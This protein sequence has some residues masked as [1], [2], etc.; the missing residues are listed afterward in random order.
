MST[1]NCVFSHAPSSSSLCL[2]SDSQVYSLRILLL[3]DAALCIC[4][5]EDRTTA[6]INYSMRTPMPQSPLGSLPVCHQH[7]F[8]P[9]S[10]TYVLVLTPVMIVLSQL[11]FTLFNQRPIVQLLRKFQ[12]LTRKVFFFFLLCVS[13]KDEVTALSNGQRLIWEPKAVMSFTHKANILKLNKHAQS[14]LQTLHCTH[15]RAAH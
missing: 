1:L 5:G 14:N 2:V 10:L 11:F 6:A 9:A 4:S 15:T 12:S 8:Q 13:N 3:S 7:F